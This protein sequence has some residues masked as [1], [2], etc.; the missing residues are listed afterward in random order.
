MTRPARIFPRRHR[1]RTLA[2]VAALAALTG[3]GVGHLTGQHD[4]RAS[5]RVT[6]QQ[7]PAGLVC[8]VPTP[9]IPARVVIRAWEDGSARAWAIDPTPAYQDAHTTREDIR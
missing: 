9:A 1:P 5:E 8:T 6:C 7:H 3:A 2:A 4:A